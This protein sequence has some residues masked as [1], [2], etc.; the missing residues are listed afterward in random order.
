MVFAI[1]APT[2]S[3]VPVASQVVAEHRMYLPLAAVATAVT[4][5]VYDIC[6]RLSRGGLVS[7][8]SV[9]VVCVLAASVAAVA[10]GVV[11]HRRNAD[12]RSELSIWQDTV[13]KSP[14]D[15]RAARISVWPCS[16]A[17]VS[18]KRLFNCSGHW[19]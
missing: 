5:G 7:R 17:D 11:T 8:R 10:L 13:D 16:S 12:Y 1:L 19:R 18:T 4:L 3:I 15:D 6:C 9:G 14:R 2:S